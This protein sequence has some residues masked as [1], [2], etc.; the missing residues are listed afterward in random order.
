MRA[1]TR[2]Y[3]APPCRSGARSALGRR[4][5]IEFRNR[6]NIFVVLHLR[7]LSPSLARHRRRRRRRRRGRLARSFSS[8]TSPPLS[9]RAATRRVFSPILRLSGFRHRQ[10][11]I[12][13]STRLSMN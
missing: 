7:H 3:A 5:E 13:L 6:P 12:H 4:T 9:T 10:A 1:Y 2:V 8:S 11:R